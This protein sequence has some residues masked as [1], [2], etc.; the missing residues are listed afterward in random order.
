MTP[1]PR[2]AE[3]GFKAPPV[4]SPVDQLRW[5]VLSRWRNHPKAHTNN[6][7][8]F[9]ANVVFDRHGWSAFK[10]YRESVHGIQQSRA[11]DVRLCP[12]YL[13]SKIAHTIRQVDNKIRGASEE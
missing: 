10:V 13:S 1:A 3:L 12:Q 7:L 9:P 2:Q 6:R 5:I 11:V 8:L 4:V